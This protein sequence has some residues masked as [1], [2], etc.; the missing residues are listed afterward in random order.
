MAFRAKKLGSGGAWLLPILD[1]A[2]P[3]CSALCLSRGRYPRPLIHSRAETE[4]LLLPSVSTVSKNSKTRDRSP[5]PSAALPSSSLRN[6]TQCWLSVVQGQVRARK[7]R[8][9][10]GP[11]PACGICW[12][13]S[14]LL[15]S[16]GSWLQPGGPPTSCLDTVSSMSICREQ[17]QSSLGLGQP[18]RWLCAVAS[19]AP[20]S[21]SPFSPL[22]T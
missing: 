3:E 13:F 8:S 20:C 11:Q 21:S 15:R 6:I 9:E 22:P 18:S 4:P 7:L 17:A 5:G 14:S 1:L 19:R 2:L 12:S 16:A 10:T